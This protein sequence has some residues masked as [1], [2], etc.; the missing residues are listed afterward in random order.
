MLECCA[1]R[2]MPSNRPKGLKVVQLNIQISQAS[3]AVDLKR[4]EILFQLPQFITECSGEI[5]I[6]RY[7]RAVAS[8]RPRDAAVN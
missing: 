7:P 5:I 8:N 6:T 4:C 3:V 2:L 1:K